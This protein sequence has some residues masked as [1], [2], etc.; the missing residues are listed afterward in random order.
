M[1][2][3]VPGSNVVVNLDPDNYSAQVVTTDPASF[4]LV[5]CATKLGSFP[6]SLPALNFPLSNL[7]IQGCA[8]TDNITAQD[9]R[10]DECLAMARTIPSG[11]LVCV[12]SSIQGNVDSAGTTASFTDCSFT[13]ITVRFTGA[14]GVVTIDEASYQKWL[15]AGVTL[16]NGTLNVLGGFSNLSSNIIVDASTTVLAAAQNGNVESPFASIPPALLVAGNNQILCAPGYYGPNL[17]ITKDVSIGALSANSDPVRYGITFPGAC[18]VDPAVIFGMQKW[19]MSGAA[20]LTLSAASSRVIATGCLLKNVLGLGQLEMYDCNANPTAMVCGTVFGSRSALPSAISL[21]G[22]NAEFLDCDFAAGCIITFTVAPGVVHLKGRSWAAFAEAGGTIV[23][24]TMI[25]DV[26]RLPNAT[27][28]IAVPAV[29]AG[30]LAYVSTSLVG[31]PLAG[32]IIAANQPVM[33]NPQADVG[34]AGGVGVGALVYAYADAP[35]SVRC[36]FIGG[37]A[38]GNQNF[39]VTVP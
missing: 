16:V 13:A 5:T 38:G 24:G 2:A 12:E 34:G 4:V 33:V 8:L 29:I 9:I 3:I 11:D 21:S 39:T 26:T 6:Q 37:L 7:R 27:I 19:T 20:S 23:N 22:V 30:S 32:R 25:E 10:Y 14:A 28:V 35:D 31:T 17:A 15:A 1:Q 18:V 36:A